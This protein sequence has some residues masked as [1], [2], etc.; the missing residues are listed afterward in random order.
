MVA[1]VI[2]DVDGTLVDSQDVIVSAMTAAFDRIGRPAPARAEVLATVGLSL[3]LSVARL[4]PDLSAED[5]AVL[6]AAYKENF[7]TGRMR[8][9]APLYDGIKALLDRLAGEDDLLLGVA[10]GKSRRGLDAL[11]ETHDLRRYFI[12]TQ[13]ADDHPSKPNPSMVLRAMSET[14]ARR[15]VMVGDTG[16]DMEMARTAG[17]DAFGVLWGYHSAAELTKAGA[18]AL[19]ST[20]ADLEQ[21]LLVWKDQG[22]E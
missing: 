12:T 14:G 10:T 17:A 6:V 3:P 19:F 9:A 22:N 15:A 18:D 1:L 20:V 21:A 7:L 2:F 11:F 5:Q 8:E 16:F 4:A 13:V